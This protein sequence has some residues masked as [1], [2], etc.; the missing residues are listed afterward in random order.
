[1]IERMPIDH[2]AAI[3]GFVIAGVFALIITVSFRGNLVSG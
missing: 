2:S 1:M 3:L